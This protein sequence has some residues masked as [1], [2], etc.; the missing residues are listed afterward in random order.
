MISH[1]ILYLIT[2]IVA[3]FLSGTF[4]IGGG[5]VVV[6]SLIFLFHLFN[7]QHFNAVHMAAGT[8][9]A[10]MIITTSVASWRHNN[11]GGIMWPVYLRMIPGIIVGTIGGVLVASQL[12]GHIIKILFGLFLLFV[13]FRMFLL[14]KPHPDRKLPDDFLLNCFSVVVGAKSG[15]LGVGG[16]TL[17]VPFLTRCNIPLRIAS[18]TSTI[19]GLT[20]A[21]V[22]TIGFIIAGWHRTLQPAFS[23][24]YIYWPAFFAV[25]FGSVLSEPLGASLAQKLPVDLGKRC[26]AVILFL[27]GL[28]LILF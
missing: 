7:M 8:S 16:G 27:V 25:A 22:G 15:L 19:C 14:V 1:L 28:R 18:G 10:I 23:F 13:S 4:G 12:D 17:T 5:I 11:Y 21:V 24:G 6:P 9:L 20:I 26:F 2:G 3:G